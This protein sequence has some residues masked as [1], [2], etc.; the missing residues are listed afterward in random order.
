MNI[1]DSAFRLETRIVLPEEE[2]HLWRVELA[3]VAKGEQ[4]WEQILPGDEQGR[5]LGVDVEKVR[6]DFDHEAIARRF[7]SVQEQRQLATRA[8]PNGRISPARTSDGSD[9]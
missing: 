1:C 9:R 3:S 7:F 8:P 6:E 4:R 2:V 5:A